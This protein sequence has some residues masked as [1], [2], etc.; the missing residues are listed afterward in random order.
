MAF[1][2]RPLANEFSWKKIFAY[3][4]KLY[5]SY[6]YN[7]Y[8]SIASGNV[9]TPNRRQANTWNND[10]L[11][12]PGSMMNFGPQYHKQCD[13]LYRRTMLYKCRDSAAVLIHY[14]NCRNEYRVILTSSSRCESPPSLGV[15]TM[16]INPFTTELYG[17][18]SSAFVT[19]TSLWWRKHYPTR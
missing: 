12:W 19:T 6:V 17:E 14:L 8:I 5:C 11:T 10:D 15:M 9:L 1:R 3:L 13:V 16:V 4:M 2:R 18:N 7:L